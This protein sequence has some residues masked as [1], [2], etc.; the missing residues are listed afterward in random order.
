MRLNDS[1]IEL[2]HCV[3]QD[4]IVTLGKN[5]SLLLTYWSLKIMVTKNIFV[6]DTGFLPRT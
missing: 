6:V 1:E 2:N 4:L 5:L 3:I